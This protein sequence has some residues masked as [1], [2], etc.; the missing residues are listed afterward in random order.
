MSDNIYTNPLTGDVFLVGDEKYLEEQRGLHHKAKLRLLSHD[1]MRIMVSR[2]EDPHQGHA[3]GIA[4]RAI[5]LAE[6]LLVELERVEQGEKME[7]EEHI[8]Q[9]SMFSAFRAPQAG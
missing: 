5:V 7:N 9:G 4:Q 8:V 3:Q 2:A 1:Y 6:A